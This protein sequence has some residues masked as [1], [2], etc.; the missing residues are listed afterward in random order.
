MCIYFFIREGGAKVN[1]QT[2][3]F[4][5]HL[6]KGYLSFF[7][8]SAHCTLYSNVSDPLNFDVDPD[9][10]I[11]VRVYGSDLK[12]NKFHFFFLILFCK[13]YKTLNSVF[14]VVLSLLF[15][16]IKQNKWFNEKK[17]NYILIILVDLY[18]SLSRFFCYP[19]PDQR[20]L[21]WIWIR[22]NDT[23]PTGSG[24]E[25][26]LYSVQWYTIA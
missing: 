8:C 6:L 18:A 24:S 11:R 20:F 2:N 15:T 22:P 14:F 12:S 10:R 21:K 1:R 3:E 13:R 4:L 5:F 19:D 17:K 25:T 23:D 26:L 7:D 9:P 16:Y